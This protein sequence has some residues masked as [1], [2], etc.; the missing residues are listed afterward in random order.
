MLPR[1]D[2]KI[3][4]NGQYQGTCNFCAESAKPSHS[5]YLLGKRNNIQPSP[6][7]QIFTSASRLER[8]VIQ[9]LRTVVWV[10]KSGL[11]VR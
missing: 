2:V 11:G 3:P 4:T 6:R 5:V 8:L 7:P 1:D 10:Y 9:R